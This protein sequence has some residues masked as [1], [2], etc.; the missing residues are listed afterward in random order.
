MAA[1]YHQVGIKAPP[2]QI[3]AALTTDQGLAHWWTRDA[4]G[5]SVVG[6]SLSFQFE[7]AVLRMQVL[8]LEPDR[9]VR[10]KCTE[11]HAEWLNTEIEFRLRAD[12]YQTFVDFRHDLWREATYLYAHCNTKWAVYLLSL[13]DYLEMGKGHPFP[14]DVQINHDE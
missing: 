6:E 3:F 1:I 14:N 13:K 4:Q 7:D 9:L 11:G 5:S 2:A 12:P 8:S 10:W